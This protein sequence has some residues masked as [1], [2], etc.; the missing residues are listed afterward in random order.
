LILGGALISIMLNPLAFAAGDW[1]T[2]RI[3]GKLGS[4]F[5]VTTSEH[6]PEIAPLKRPPLRDH[7]ILVG[8][9]RV[10]RIIVEALQQRGQQFVV[11][12]AADSG[13]SQ[14]TGTTF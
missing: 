4:S 5:P 11:V 8:Y 10:G 9:G 3:E 2:P 14:I 13:S 1:L 6:T 12:E 7:T